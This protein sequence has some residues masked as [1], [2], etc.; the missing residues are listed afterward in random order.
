MDILGVSQAEATYADLVNCRSMELVTLKADS[1]DKYDAPPEFLA[2]NP[3]PADEVFAAIH[4]DQQYFDPKT[5]ETRDGKEYFLDECEFCGEGGQPRAEGETCRCAHCGLTRGLPSAAARRKEFYSSAGSDGGHLFDRSKVY[6]DNANRFVRAFMRKNTNKPTVLDLIEVQERMIQVRL[7]PLERVLYENA[8]RSM[9]NASG[10]AEQAK[11]RRLLQIC[12]HFET[13]A[14][15]ANSIEAAF[16]E[17]K[18]ETCLEFVERVQN[19]LYLIRKFHAAK[20]ATE[21]VN[22]DEALGGTIRMGVPAK[23]PWPAELKARLMGGAVSNAAD[24]ELEGYLASVLAT[25]CINVE[26]TPKD[27][28]VAQAF[29]QV[30][31]RDETPA[32][33]QKKL[34][35]P[36]FE[37]LMLELK[38]AQELREREGS[39]L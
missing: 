1:A 2:G 29:A 19:L 24:N 30:R 38:D 21:F 8:E 3:T 18:R 22:D 15:G 26:H 34:L 36:Y 39:D 31:P 16:A 37:Y 11:K 9:R 17:Q 25:H 35:A 4:D 33:G 27:K 12:S 14:G 13:G 7:T 5:L 10:A 32:A 6:V 23:F 28:I 20:H